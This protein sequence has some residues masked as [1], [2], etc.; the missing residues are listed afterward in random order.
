M[1]RT[2]VFTAL[3]VF[4]AA[5]SC[6]NDT[7]NTISWLDGGPAVRVVT[8]APSRAEV[9]AATGAL[10]QAIAELPS[11]GLAKLDRT[12][13]VSFGQTLI[14]GPLF[15]DYAAMATDYTGA[16]S[17]GQFAWDTA[18]RTFR[19]GLGNGVE[20][21][22][23]QESHILVK[24]VHVGTIQDGWVVMHSGAVGNSG[25]YEVVPA[26]ASV[27]MKK[28]RVLGMATENIAP[29]AEGLVTVRGNVSGL[30]SDGSAYGTSGWTD[31]QEVYLSTNTL[32]YVTAV[33]PEAPFPKILI[34]NVVSSH[35]VNGQIYVC[36]KSFGGIRDLDDINGT[37]L[38]ESGQFMV[39]DAARGVFDFT[40]NIASYAETG[41]VAAVASD[42]AALSNTV[43]NLPY[44]TVISNKLYLVT[45]EEE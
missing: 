34:G 32:G 16:L 11:G 12:N 3:S 26:I 14:G 33:E 41:T 19:F 25:K 15:G 28:H 17:Q 9:A 43:A 30:G 6:A 13:D 5:L 29:G 2:S 37:P 35:G 44:L 40:R 20:L 24:N 18:W 21:Q 45:P 38:T 39:Y 1:K 4:C 31:N 42:L 22:A 10:W 8:N 27:G 23:G 7:N 36:V